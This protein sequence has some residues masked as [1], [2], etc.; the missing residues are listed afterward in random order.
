VRRAASIDAGGSHSRRTLSQGLGVEVVDF[1]CSATVGR[2]GAEEPN[3]T[4]SIVFI[5]RGVFARCHRGETLLADPNQ[6]LF[7]NQAQPYRYEHPLPGGD[8]CTI[9]ALETGAAL[10]AVAP[11]S[12][13]DAERPEAPFRPGRAPASALTARLHFELL[14]TLRGDRPELV[15]QD[16][17]AQ[18]IDEALRAA[19]AGEPRNLA[20]SGSRA[21]ARRRERVEAVRFLLNRQLESPPTLGELAAELGCSPFHVSRSF[22]RETG[23]TLRGYLGRL[24][25]RL[26]ADRL[27]HGELDLTTLALDLGFADHSHLT[28][29]FRREW[30]MPPSQFRAR[31]QHHGRD[32]ASIRSR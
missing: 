3:P 8:E 30:G 25:A 9:L 26:A 16:V 5:R 23:Q 7:F 17:A 19:Y 1:R 13:R 22:R 12:P 6:I 10:A 27:A 4:H 2:M 21:G 29:T 31:S 18:L 15:R 20:P 32:R 11:F 28:R 24:R 14:A